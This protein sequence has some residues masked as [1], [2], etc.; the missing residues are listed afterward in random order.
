MTRLPS[1]AAA[2]SS[3]P[4]SAKITGRSAMQG[5]IWHEGYQAGKLQADLFPD[6]L[7]A[8]ERW[9][10]AGSPSTPACTSRCSELKFSPPEATQEAILSKL[11]AHLE[12][13][14][15]LLQ[16]CCNI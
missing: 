5:L 3:S 9:H 16:Y 1:A 6:V 8:L 7:P 11:C 12:R 13:R 10:A 14:S 2:L 15:C 4:A